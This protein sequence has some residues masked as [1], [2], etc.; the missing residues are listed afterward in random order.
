M[1]KEVFEM[2]IKNIDITNEQYLKA[3]RKK[4]YLARY[5]RVG[6]TMKPR[7]RVFNMDGENG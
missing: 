3:K 7:F 2:E 1:E 6:K 5:R 4:R